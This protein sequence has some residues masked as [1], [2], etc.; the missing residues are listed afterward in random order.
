MARKPTL[1]SVAKAAGVSI[2]TVS[3]VM[4]STGRISAETR[5]KVLNAANALH[6]IPDSRAASMRSGVNREIGFVINQLANPFNAEVIGGVVDLLEAEG[7]LVSIL[8]TRDDAVRQGRHLEAFIRH[9]RGGLLW[10]PATDTPDAT[11]DI[12]AKHGIPTVTFLRRV[13]DKIDHVG[14]RNA[15]AIATATTYLADMGHKSI[16]YL[17][18]TD[19]AAVRRERIAG[20]CA[21]L[22]GRGLGP[23]IVWESAD[24]KPAALDAVIR[25]RAAHP[26][27]TAIVCNGDTVALGACLGILK[28]GLQPGVDISVI[29][30]DDVQEAAVATPP[31]TTMAVSPHRLGRKLARVL[32]DR[33]QDPAMPVSVSEITAELII[34]DST[35]VPMPDHQQSVLSR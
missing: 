24:N 11:F 31:L 5:E 29:G 12:L 6:Y 35:G 23:A 1:A 9:G 34:R 10:V 33:I 4:R 19:M 28:M 26:N 8:D 13:S 30:F 17:G 27:V 7:Y 16:A 21:T 20:Y 2:P 32:L 3:Q 22:A 15:E 14:I 18:G 25:L